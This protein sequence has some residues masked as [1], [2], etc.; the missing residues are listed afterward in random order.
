[1]TAKTLPLTR[2]SVWKKLHAH[3]KAITREARRQAR[4]LLAREMLSL[5]LR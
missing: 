1:M 2:R 5:G 3:F 4:E